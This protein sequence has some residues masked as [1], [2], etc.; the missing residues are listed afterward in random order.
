[1]E[2]AT[3][4]LTDVVEDVQETAID[5]VTDVQETATDVV[6][7]VEETAQSVVED[8]AAELKTEEPAVSD[9]LSVAGFDL[10]KVSDMIDGSSAND[11]TKLALKTGLQQAKDNPDQL[12]AILDQ[13]KAALQK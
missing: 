11:M 10:A 8:A 4:T 13:I 5:V 6:Q 3:E 7:D 1:M 12:K 2:T 9:P